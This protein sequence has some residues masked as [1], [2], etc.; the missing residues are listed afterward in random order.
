MKKF[1]VTLLIAVLLLTQITVMAEFYFEIIPESSLDRSEL[2]RQKHISDSL[3]Y[4]NNIK[5]I[6]GKL[7]MGDA[8]FDVETATILYNKTGSIEW[9]HIPTEEG[10][11]ARKTNNDGIP[12]SLMGANPL[13]VFDNEFNIVRE[14]NFDG[15]AFVR[16]VDYYNGIYYCIYSQKGREVWHDDIGENVTWE[17]IDDPTKSVDN[18]RLVI[19]KNITV[20]S[21]DLENWIKIEEMPVM[22]IKPKING[23]ISWVDGQISIANQDMRNI[24]YEGKTPNYITNFGEWFVFQNDD[25]AIYL[26]NDNV[27]FLK[28]YIPN[29]NELFNSTEHA[30]YWVDGIPVFSDTRIKIEGIYELNGDIVVIWSLDQRMTN[31]YLT[32]PK[33]LV[34]D[35][36]ERLK[37]VP[38]LSLNG[39]ILAFEETPVIEAGRTLVPMRFLFEQMG[40]KVDWNESTETATVAKDGETISF[41]IN[42]VSAKINSNTKLMDVP[43]KLINDKTMVPLRFLSENLGYNVEWDEATRMVTIT[44][45]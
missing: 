20:M 7:Y 28:V 5:E 32:I 8:L 19:R 17:P 45:E 31:T 21:A 34:Y 43:A 6:N 16:E 30:S 22:P 25:T 23:D 44:T 10:Y 11:I 38:Y 24:V 12:S 42:S 26:S 36:L 35:E 2:F 15:E 33:Q 40:A 29:E 37:S 13:Y 39:T 27:N 41:Q 18:S 4:L 14:I 9:E 1:T 3:G